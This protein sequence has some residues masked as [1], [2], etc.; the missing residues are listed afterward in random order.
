MDGYL[1]IVGDLLAAISLPT[2]AYPGQTPVPPWVSATSTSRPPRSLRTTWASV[3]RACQSGSFVGVG[4]GQEFLQVDHQRGAV[5]GAQ[6]MRL[7]RRTWHR[8]LL[9]GA[10]ASRQ[11]AGPHLSSATWGRPIAYT[12]AAG[13]AARAAHRRAG[14]ADAAHG[15]SEPDRDRDV[16]VLRVGLGL[17]ARSVRSSGYG[18]RSR[19]GSG[20]RCA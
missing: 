19:T 1:E 14:R 15:V 10:C 12:A 4:R 18:G 20:R 13:V 9:E 3:R 2:N 17:S 7:P 5:C 11:P 16:H 8:V 6:R